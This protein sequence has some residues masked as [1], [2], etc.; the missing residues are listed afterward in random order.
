MGDIKAGDRFEVFIKSVLLAVGDN[1][2]ARYHGL[3]EHG[4]ERARIERRL[5]DREQNLCVAP[6]FHIGACF[7]I[8]VV[9]VDGLDEIRCCFA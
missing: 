5:F 8:R 2:A 3:A 1:A 6:E 4:V 7:A 9:I